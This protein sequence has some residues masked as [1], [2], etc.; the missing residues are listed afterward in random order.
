MVAQTGQQPSATLGSWGLSLLKGSAHQEAA[1]EAIRY[2]TS[3]AAQRE[4]FIEKGYTPTQQSLFS[5]PAL[6]AV[7][8]VLPDIG[9][10]LDVAIERPPTP[11][12]AQLSD[13]L[14]RRLSAILTGEQPV[15]SAM[16]EAQTSSEVILKSAGGTA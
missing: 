8:P 1:V 9:R 12:Y 2:L 15:Q 5:D 11:L 16:G 3:E 14:Q 6:T 10:A 13:V 7:S 4:R